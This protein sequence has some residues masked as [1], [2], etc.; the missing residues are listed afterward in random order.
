[1]EHRFTRL[2]S[3]ANIG[4]RAPVRPFGAAWPGGPAP[5][6][7]ALHGCPLLGS[8]RGAASPSPR[9]GA[10]EVCRRSVASKR[11]SQVAD[12]PFQSSLDF[13]QFRPSCGGGQR[14]LAFRR[15]GDFEAQG[16]QR[17]EQPREVFCSGPSGKWSVMGRR[18][19]STAEPS[20][21]SSIVASTLTRRNEGAPRPTLEM[22]ASSRATLHDVTWSRMHQIAGVGDGLECFPC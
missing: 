4:T 15:V 19:S 16:N 10:G 8:P 7:V 9:R 5:P 6:R 2:G 1:M 14:L 13:H 21:P 18:V 12:G 3:V 22:S 11:A 20:L 17:I